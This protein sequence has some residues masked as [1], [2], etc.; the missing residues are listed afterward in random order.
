MIALKKEELYKF[1]SDFGLNEI[2]I[3]LYLYLIR[4]GPEKASAISKTL[5][6]HKMQVYRTLQHLEKKGVVEITFHQP[7]QFTAKPF[8]EILQKYKNTL[9]N[10]LQIIIKNEKDLLQLLKT[11]TT[12]SEQEATGTL[13]IIEGQKRISRETINTGIKAQKIIR[14]MTFIENLQNVYSLG[15]F[16]YLKNPNRKSRAQFLILTKKEKTTPIEKKIIKELLKI[17]KL[18]IRYS[19]ERLSCY[20]SLIISDNKEF[21]LVTTLEEKNLKNKIHLT[22]LYSN[23]PVLSAILVDYFIQLWKKSK[24]IKLILIS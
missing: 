19:T 8:K 16:E 15:I 22:G 23:N 7:K 17:P 10:S 1:L 21:G 12:I 4:K 5:K 24:P 18:A 9:E 11:F 13:R 6:L 3:K 14:K 2:E 20:T